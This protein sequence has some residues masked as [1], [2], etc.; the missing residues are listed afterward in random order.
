MVRL[1][2]WLPLLF[3]VAGALLFVRVEVRLR[4]RQLEGEFLASVKLCAAVP[5][6]RVEGTW[7]IGGDLCWAFYSSFAFKARSGQ[8]P[9]RIGA[10]RKKGSVNG[11]H[12]VRWLFQKRRVRALTAKVALGFAADAPATAKACGLLQSVLSPWGV[13]LRAH[14][15]RADVE[16]IPVFTEGIAAIDFHGIADL[17]SCHI[18]GG[19]INAKRRNKHGTKTPH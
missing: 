11:W 16:V 17:F 9:L 4:A 14:R 6:F 8:M 19:W 15:C 1:W 3:V 12:M 10:I 13:W 7:R 5:L 18:I 2:V